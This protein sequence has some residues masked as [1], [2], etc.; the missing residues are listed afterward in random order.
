MLYLATVDMLGL[1]VFSPM[2]VSIV[3]HTKPGLIYSSFLFNLKAMVYLI[4]VLKMDCFP[5]SYFE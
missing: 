5:E 4:K 3:M 2:Q 1:K